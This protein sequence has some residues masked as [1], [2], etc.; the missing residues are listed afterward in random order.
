V[1]AVRDV[2]GVD[3]VMSR[4]SSGEAVIH[5]R[6]GE[7]RFHPDDARPKLRD[8][9]GAGWH[10]DGELAAVEAT[11]EDGVLRSAAY[12]DALGRVWAALECPT[13]GDVLLSAAPGWEFPDWGGVDHVGAGSHGSLHALDSLGALVFVGVDAPPER[14]AD[15]AWSIADVTPMVLGHFGLRFG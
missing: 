3:L 12:P 10:V 8:R 15:G 13:S 9:R 7:L 4:A 5:S 14:A 1:S 11:I 6:H 2:E